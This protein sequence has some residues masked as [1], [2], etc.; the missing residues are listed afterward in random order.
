MNT[1]IGGQ[2]VVPEVVASH[3]HIN[4]GDAVADFGAGS[5]YF[6]KSL[7]TRA[8]GAG[9]VYACEIQK[10]LVEKIVDLA[11]A[12]HL[13]NIHPLWCDLE[14]INGI[15]IQ[16]NTLDTGI[17]VN[18]LFQIQDKET[19][20]KEI[21]RTLRSGGKLFIIDW[22]ESYG[23]LG[24]RPS[25]VISVSEAKALLES[26]QFIFEREFPAGEHHYGLAFRKI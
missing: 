23:G 26:N 3:F 1:L 17:L 24:P 19:A 8:G 22:T 11:R 20:I 16:S 9:R 14:E 15:K 2:F 12:Q 5:G 13:H 4:E 25:D 6:L 21:G 10:S 7:S 18:T